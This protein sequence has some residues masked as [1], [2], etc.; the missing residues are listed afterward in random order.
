MRPTNFTNGVKKGVHG[1]CFHK[2][3]MVAHTVTLYNAWKLAH[4][5]HLAICEDKMDDTLVEEKLCINSAMRGF[6]TTN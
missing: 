5:T 2:T 4:T 1:N 3:I 6:H